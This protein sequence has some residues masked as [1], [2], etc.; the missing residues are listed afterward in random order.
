[1]HER[2]QEDEEDHV[3][4]DLERGQ[5]GK[6]ADPEPREH[7]EDRVRHS[8]RPREPGDRGDDTEQRDQQLD[9]VHALP[10]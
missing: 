5:S 7:Q 8:Q 6:E 3:G 1:V 9:L 10:F 2:G 4:I